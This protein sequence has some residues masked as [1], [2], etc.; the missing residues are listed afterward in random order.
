MNIIFFGVRLLL[1]NFCYFIF[2]SVII[3]VVFVGNIIFVTTVAAVAV[4]QCLLAS[5]FRFF[6]FASR[7]Y[8]VCVLFGR[9]S[10]RRSCL[11]LRL[12][13]NHRR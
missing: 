1:C 6:H 4:C 3:A 11:P 5:Y 9:D 10:V 13:F 12:R 7:D 2:V 8:F